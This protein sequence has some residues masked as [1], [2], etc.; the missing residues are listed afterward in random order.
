MAVAFALYISPKEEVP[1]GAI[2]YIKNRGHLIGVLEP[3]TLNYFIYKGEAF[4]FGLTM[5]Q[6]FSR[7][8]EVPLKVIAC[9][10]VSQAYYYLD[11]HVADIMAYN[12]PVTRLGRNLAHFSSPL[13]ETNLVLVQRSADRGKHDSSSSFISTLKE[14]HHDTVV[15][16]QNTFLQ[17]LYKRFLAKAGR[18]VFLKEVSATPEE[19]FRMVSDN[20]INYTLC[21]ENLAVVLNQAYRNTDIAIA[22][23]KS[24]PM[25]WALNHSSDSLLAILDYWLDSIASK[26]LLNKTYRNIYHNP[27]VVN[28]FRSDYFS[29]VS[30]RISPWDEQ[31]QLYSKLF[32]WDWRLVASLMYTE[33]NFV[34]GLTSH[35]D[36]YGLMQMI[37][38][39]AEIYGLDT[40]STASHQIMAGVKYLKWIDRHLPHEIRD[41]R[42]RASFTLAAYN[43]GIGRVLSLRKKA[44]EYGKDQN[45]WHGNVEYYLLSRSHADPYGHADTLREFPVNYSMDGYVDGIINRYYH[46]LNLVSD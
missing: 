14:L 19:L 34:R 33:S 39:T 9:S 18:D 21:P 3:N 44:E 23:T 36:A 5:L 4:G 24:Y 37:P 42:E 32:W 10:T 22:A 38:I 26:R 12:L 29:L 1:K 25:A 11:Y 20:S 40:T 28:H 13:Q 43:V 6:E 41:P 31:L 46:Y 27:R 30:N 16:Q 35:K 8:L 17:Q 2:Q 45:R 15:V 7:Y